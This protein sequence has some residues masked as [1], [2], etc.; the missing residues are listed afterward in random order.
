MLRE[1][2]KWPPWLKG[3]NGFYLLSC[4]ATT[5]SILQPPLSEPSWQW[6]FGA[7]GGTIISIVGVTIILLV[8]GDTI[9]KTTAAHHAE[10]LAVRLVRVVKGLSW[11][12]TPAVTVL[13][14]IATAFGKL[15]GA[16][17]VGGSLIGAGRDP[18]YDQC[19]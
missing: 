3:R 16:H 10:V 14:W 12:F 9:P 2:N 19:R 13:S 4:W 11:V 8:F 15:I 17:T 6:I 1:P 7:G 18:D 5:S